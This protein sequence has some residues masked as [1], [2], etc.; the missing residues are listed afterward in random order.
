MGQAWYPIQAHGKFHVH[1][2]GH[3]PLHMPT[4]QQKGQQHL[5]K[6]LPHLK[7]QPHPFKPTPPSLYCLACVHTILLL[8]LPYPRTQ[9]RHVLSATKSISRSQPTHEKSSMIKDWLID[10]GCSEHMTPFFDDI[11]DTSKPTNTVVEVANCHI[12]KAINK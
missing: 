1:Y 8:L 6:N 10:S 11:I 12:V 3:Q 5:N 9:K 7:T 2:S 4:M